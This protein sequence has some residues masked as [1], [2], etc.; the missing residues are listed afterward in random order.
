M[1]SEQKPRKE[2]WIEQEDYT[3]LL[4]VYRYKPDSTDFQVFHVIEYSAL[5][6]AEKKLGKAI[7]ALEEID[8]L[9]DDQCWYDAAAV[10]TRILKKLRSAE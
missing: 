7:A 8:C 2:F 1:T 4:S 5:E 10:C 6:Q 3:E 9:L